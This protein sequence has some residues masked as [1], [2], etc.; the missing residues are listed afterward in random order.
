MDEDRR[1]RPTLVSVLRSKTRPV[2]LAAAACPGTIS[3]MSVKELPVERNKMKKMSP[4][5]FSCS[6]SALLGAPAVGLLAASSPALAADPIKIGVI[7][8]AQ[9]IAGASI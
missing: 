9:A 5:S 2:L 6:L 1:Q 4:S 3:S 8:E 7:A